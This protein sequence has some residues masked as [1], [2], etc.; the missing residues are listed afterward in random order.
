MRSLILFG[1]V[2]LG[3]NGCIIAEEKFATHKLAE[4]GY[5]VA[6]SQSILNVGM[7]V[8]GSPLTVEQAV[9]AKA[10]KLCANDHRLSEP[11]MRK[12]PEYLEAEKVWI[13]T[14]K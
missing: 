11:E 3:L 13:V 7:D 5:E 8:Y 4:G 1:A 10:K 14:C 9:L 12:R 6:L 2:I